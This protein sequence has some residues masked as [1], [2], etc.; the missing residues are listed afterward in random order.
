MIIIQTILAF[1]IV[2]GIIVIVH[3]A[4]H[5][6]AARLMKVRIDT[7]SFG[8]G[9]RLFGKKFGETDFRV[10]LVP[11]GGYVKMAGEDEY[12]AD[13]L[14]P[15]EFQSKNRG[16][17]I[18]ILIMGPLMNIFLSLFI[19]SIVN[20]V[21]IEKEKYKS[22]IP[23][24]GF[25]EQ[26]SPADKAGLKRGDIILSINKKKIMNW[27][28]LELTVGYNPNEEL[29]IEYKRGNIKRST[30]IRV[31]MLTQKNLNPAGFYYDYKT[32]VFS[33]EKEFPA[34]KSGLKNGDIIVAINNNP[35]SFFDMGDVISSNP[36]KPLL[37]RIK[38]GSELINLTIVPRKVKEKGIIGIT[39]IPYSPVIK[40][41][42][43][44]FGAVGKSYKEL[45]DLTV[46][47]FSA[48]KKMIVGK[49]SPKHLSGPIEIAKFSQRA[50]KSGF[51]N[52]FILIAFISLQLGIINLFP[53]PALDG[54]HLMIYS[55][56]AVIRREFSKKVK[57]RLINI[58]FFILISLMV[59]VVL[60][61]VAK[62][63]PNGWSSLIPF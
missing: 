41:R 20:M 47:T 54:G 22:E 29:H 51:S 46:L 61:D 7:F 21:G 26:G 8:F 28:D 19:L 49:I 15:Y 6:I 53:I 33:I 44:L 16:Q 63:L 59:F 38:R 58:G 39:R 5:F 11:L 43:G 24:I 10:S 35:V 45:I 12:N 18:F 57:E 37:F 60:N 2:F 17:K 1:L 55:V 9:K 56:E 32:E 50:M 31:K 4:G 14:K 42:Y 34:F 3:E 13:D 25:V 30:S 48:F 52:F 62:A 27:K 23:E 40:V 36:G